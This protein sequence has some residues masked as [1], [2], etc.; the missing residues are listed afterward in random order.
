[1]FGQVLCA[2]HSVR[3]C[4]DI[5]FPSGLWSPAGSFSH[6]CSGEGWRGYVTGTRPYPARVRAGSELTS[7]ESVCDLPGLGAT[8]H[9]CTLTHTCTHCAHALHT[10]VSAYGLCTHSALTVCTQYMHT[11]SLHMHSAHTVSALHT[12]SLHTTHSAHTVSVHTWSQHTVSAR[13]V[14]EHTV[15]ALHAVSAHTHSVHMCSAHTKHNL[16][17]CNPPTHSFCTHRTPSLHT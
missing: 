13:T 4:T 14:S 2:R 6:L 7:V 8:Q 11:P 3:P 10:L 1:M 5:T 9:P 12:Q 16:Y 15:S 17:T